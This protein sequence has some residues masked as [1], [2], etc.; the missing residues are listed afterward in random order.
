MDPDSFPEWLADLHY[1]AGEELPALVEHWQLGSAFHLVGDSTGG[2]FALQYAL[3]TNSEKMASMVL[4]SAFSDTVLMYNAQWEP[5]TGTLV[6][7]QSL[8]E[9]ASGP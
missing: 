6:A 7:C 9:I 8:C 2:A 5:L 3:D 1:Y 4:S